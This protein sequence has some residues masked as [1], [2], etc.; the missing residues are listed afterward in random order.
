MDRR[1]T[2]A[3]PLGFMGLPAAIGARAS[4]KG[5]GPGPGPLKRGPGLGPGLSKGPQ[6]NLSGHVAARGPG[7]SRRHMTRQIRLRKLVVVHI[8]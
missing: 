1:R 6:S 2:N 4:Q 8:Y 5:P 3:K 7:P